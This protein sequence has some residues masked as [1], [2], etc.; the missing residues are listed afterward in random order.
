MAPRAGRL[1]EDDRGRPQG[2]QRA[3]QLHRIPLAQH[4]KHRHEPC[5][6]NQLA[7]SGTHLDHR[8]WVVAPIED[9]TRM[10]SDHLQASWPARRGEAFANRGVV[11]HV[12]R[13]GG[14]DRERCV[15][16]LIVA[17]QREAQ[18]AMLKAWSGDAQ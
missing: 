6:A 11:G 3:K 16:R 14:R 10:L 8:R 4:C 18:V 5:S 17:D 12:E 15:R 7:E 1:G 13:V 9:D 2:A